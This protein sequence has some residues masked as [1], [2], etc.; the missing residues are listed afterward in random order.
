[1]IKSLK[2]VGLNKYES[3]AYI[4]LITFGGKLSASRIAAHATI[5]YGRVYDILE[6]LMNKGL[7]SV[8]P[9]SPK[10]YSATDP[11]ILKA[12]IKK[13]KI[14]LDKLEKDVDQ[15][16]SFYLKQAP[17]AVWMVRG[18]KNF[19]NLLKSIPDTKRYKYA[20]KYNVE[21]HPDIVKMFRKMPKNIDIKDL[22][23]VEKETK[24]NISAW[25]KIGKKMKKIK[26]EGISL[27]IVDDKYV[28]IGLIKANTTLLIRDVTFAKVM[29][30]M[31]IETYKVAEKA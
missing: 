27:T 26:N 4:T 17:E 1:M 5:P 16:K 24:D 19:Y 11:S 25:K 9:E 23:R 6:S 21:Y 3:N 18:K 31:F 14:E 20:I 29:K 7:I 8:S 22:V 2:I 15:L 13:K 12:H 10:L 30:K 28:M